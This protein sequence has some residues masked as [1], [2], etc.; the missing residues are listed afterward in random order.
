MLDAEPREILRMPSESWLPLIVAIVLSGMFAM[1]LT[2]HYIVA[3]GFAL[4]VA[5]VV[6]LWHLHEPEEPVDAL[7]L[8][9]PEGQ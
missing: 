5:A 9:E 7:E 8:V 3:G 6:A 2:Q 4:G 1:L